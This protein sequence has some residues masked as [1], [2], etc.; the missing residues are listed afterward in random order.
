MIRHAV[1][2]APTLRRRTNAVNDDL[3]EAKSLLE[4]PHIDAQEKNII[5][6]GAAFVS[7]KF[8][9]GDRFQDTVN[10][11]CAMSMRWFAPRVDHFTSNNFVCLS[12][13]PPYIYTSKFQRHLRFL[14]NASDTS[15]RGGGYWFWKSVIVNHTLH[16]IAENALLL[17]ADIDTPISDVWHVMN[18]IRAH[19]TFAIR[20]QANYPEYVWTKEDTFHAL[21]ISRDSPHR[22]SGQFWANQWV[23]RNTPSMRRFI[24]TWV[25]LMSDWHLISDEPSVLPNNVMFQENRHDQSMLSLLVKTRLR[26]VRDKGLWS[27]GVDAS[28]AQL[29]NTSTKPWY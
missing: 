12:T 15:A 17:F 25:T 22:S 19:E 7:G 13:F 18:D 9:P 5:L 16:N 1:A 2:R 4:R 3:D 27:F 6:R 24:E 8:G 26:R 28:V 14:T 10:E 20:P 11:C 29:T 23:I 21:N